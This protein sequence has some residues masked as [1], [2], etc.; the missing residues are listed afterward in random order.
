MSATFYL[1]G[2]IKNTVEKYVRVRFE[3]GPVHKPR[4]KLRKMK[5]PC[6]RTDENKAQTTRRKDKKATH[7]GMGEVVKANNMRPQASQWG[8]SKRNSVYTS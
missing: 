3:Q 5:A 8:E 4:P 1:E 2:L 7:T 6:I